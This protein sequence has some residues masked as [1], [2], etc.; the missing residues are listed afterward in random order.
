MNAKKIQTVSELR[1]KIQKA[2]SVVL[3]DY[4]GLTHKQAEELHRQMKKAAGEFTV[5]KNTLLRIAAKDAGND[6]LAKNNV[7]GPIAALFAF[8]DEF[9]PLRELGKFIK[10]AGL[11]AIKLAYINSTEY[12][13]ERTLAIARLPDLQT[14][15][16]QL[17]YTLNANMQKLVY[18]L[19]HVKK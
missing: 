18:I 12:D 8:E 1:E 7:S 2:K 4:R 10:T 15:R 13:A 6:Q 19:S 3:A 5:V 16:A 17:V 9:A 11:P 14:L